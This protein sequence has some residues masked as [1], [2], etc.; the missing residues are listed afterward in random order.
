MGDLRNI[1]LV[2]PMGSGKTAVGKRLARRLRLRFVDSD[3]EIERRTG[4]DI[5]LIFEKEG[6]AG[7]RV[8]ESAVIL[9]LV[10]L[11]GLV[12]STGG[13][14]ILLP[15][16][17]AALQSSGTVVYL[18]TSVARQAER[19]RRSV[20]RPL[21]AGAIDLTA[22]LA[23]LMAYRAPLYAEVA[24]LTVQTDGSRVQDIVER[25]VAA[26][27]GFAPDDAPPPPDVGGPGRIL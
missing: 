27:P 20:H 2:G 17:R 23:E 10:T 9:D 7:F 25:I 6:E 8:R 18:E 13:G 3:L 19:V 5:T 21:L 22:R 26:L 1:F 11:P 12:I 14:A 4:A 16:N 24:H 15:E